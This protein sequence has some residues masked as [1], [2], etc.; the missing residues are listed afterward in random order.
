[1]TGVL[2]PSGG[3]PAGLRKPL[4]ADDAA[5]AGAKGHAAGIVFVAPDGDILLLRRAPTEKNFGGHWSLPGGGVD[6]GETPEQGALREAREEIGAEIPSGSPGR[7]LDRRITPTGLAFHTFA[8]PVTEKFTPVLNDEHTGYAWANLDMLPGPLHPAVEQTLKERV[9]VAGDLDPDGWKGVREGF[10]RW[11]AGEPGGAA[12]EDLGDRDEVTM[13]VPLLLRLLEHAYEDVD[14][15]EALHKMAEKAA[16]G[17]AALGMADYERIIGDAAKLS[18]AEVQ[19]G[20]AIDDD[21]CRRCAHFQPDGPHCDLVADPIDPEGWCER[22]L[23]DQL[24][25]DSAR[26]AMD[27]ASVREVDR[28]GRLRVVRA[29]ITKADVNPYLGREIPGYRDLGLEPDKVYMMLRPPEELERAAPTL[30]GVPLLRK[31]IPVSADDPKQADVV[32]AIGTGAVFEYPYLDNSLIVWVAKDIE[33][34]ESDEKRELSAGYH[35]RPEMTPGN[36][37]G[38]H[39]DGVMRDIAFNHVALVEDGRAGPDVVVGDSRETLDMAAKKPTRL[40][41]IA[42]GYT[43]RAIRPLLAM[44]AQVD[45]MPIFKDVT[46]KTFNPKSITKQVA[47][48]LK[49]KTIAMDVDIAHVN[50]MLDKLGSVAG[51]EPKTADESVSEPQHKA[52]EAAAHGKSNLGIPEEVGKE[53]EKADKGKTF[54][55]E[56]LKA[57]LAEKGVAQD[58]I[59]GALELIHHEP[60]AGDEVEINVDPD[61]DEEKYPPAAADADKDDDKE[62]KEMVTKHA[63]DSAIGAAVKAA[64]A[65]ARKTEREIAGARDRVRPLVGALASDLAFD[66]AD[67]VYRHALK[68]LGHPVADDVRGSAL[69]TILD[70]IPAPG[71]AQETRR[72]AMDSAASTENKL[73]D[74]IPGIDRI[75]AA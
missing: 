35:Y 70:L 6:A 62:N 72:I 48:A 68:M 69:T 15:D 57:Y 73:G 28:D 29:H 55:A 60:K 75:R 9:G 11:A 22:F 24:V 43:A 23:V 30:N 31:H 53:F 63:M 37:D 65:A 20:P 67:D 71:R 8:F 12:D 25:T 7:L 44:D 16:A 18:H 26:L 51:K 36:F 19:Y 5:A 42:L 61:D 47:D 59:D 50:S 13:S 49:G 17:G 21:R 32:G 3:I 54:D 66:S 2:A 38:K 33:G 27:R 58:V 14:S 1:M 4:A 45:L 52:M 46:T 64:T 10:A 56:P 41:A 74:L 39:F 34:I 40:A